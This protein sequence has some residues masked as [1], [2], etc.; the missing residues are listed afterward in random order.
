MKKLLL[1][2]ALI[3]CFTT[4]KAGGFGL[5]L[6]PKFGYQKIMLSNKET[7]INKNFNNSWTAGLFIRMHIG[8]T[9]C[10]VLQ[11]ELLYFNSEE[12]F[13]IKNANN[14][15]LTLKQ[16]NLSLPIF[17]GYQIGDGMV[18]GRLTVGPVLNFVVGQQNNSDI[19]V[20]GLNIEANKLTWGA[21]VNLGFDIWC[22][23]L[24]ACY[25]LGISEVYK[26]NTVTTSDEKTKQNMFIVTLGIRLFN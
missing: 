7:E 8:S 4:V 17:L 2:L 26:N 3:I 13:E 14:P 19:I 6:G 18:R 16:Q 24:D 15:T 12:I 21:A 5:S 25:S 11:P 23:T 20:E 10:F 9:H 22:I 1:T